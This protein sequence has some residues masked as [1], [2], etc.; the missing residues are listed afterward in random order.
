MEELLRKREVKRLPPGSLFEGRR[1]EEE[2]Y[3]FK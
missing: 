2:L 1:Y 3:V